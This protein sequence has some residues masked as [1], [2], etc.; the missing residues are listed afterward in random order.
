MLLGEN[1]KFLKISKEVNWTHLNR[2]DPLKL[3]IIQLFPALRNLF[4]PGK[5]QD[6]PIFPWNPLPSITRIKEIFL[7]SQYLVIFKLSVRQ[8]H[9]AQTTEKHNATSWQTSYRWPMPT[10][11]ALRDLTPYS[12]FR[13]PLSSLPLFI[14]NKMVAYYY[15]HHSWGD[16]AISIQAKCFITPDVNIFKVSRPYVWHTNTGKLSCQPRALCPMYYMC[17]HGAAT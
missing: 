16:T 17:L 7:P 5:P 8:L 6:F 4:S 1:L 10:R 15:L 13:I 11:S 12:H 2:S 14:I 9:K 3:N